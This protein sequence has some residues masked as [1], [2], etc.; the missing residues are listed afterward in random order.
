MSGQQFCRSLQRWGR[1]GESVCGQQSEAIE[2][3]MV[4]TR[5]AYRLRNG[6]DGSAD[7]PDIAF[8]GWSGL[9]GGEPSGHVNL[10]CKFRV[11]GLESLSR[12]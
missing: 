5:R 8:R 6:Q 10:A 1:G 12:D 3:H 9:A 2:K 4:R 7:L 11:K